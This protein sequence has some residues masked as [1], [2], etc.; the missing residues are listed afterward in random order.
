MDGPQM[1]GQLGRRSATSIA[2]GGLCP[3]SRVNQ[4]AAS[5]VVKM[6]SCWGP[7]VDLRLQETHGICES[8]PSPNRVIFFHVKL[9]LFVAV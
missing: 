4:M 8:A 5:G 1:H 2:L 9:T 6:G 7:V 3:C